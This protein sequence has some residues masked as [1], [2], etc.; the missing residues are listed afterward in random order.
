VLGLVADA[1]ADIFAVIVV[2]CIDL[3][4]VMYESMFIGALFIK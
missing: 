4:L 3:G 1:D 2:V